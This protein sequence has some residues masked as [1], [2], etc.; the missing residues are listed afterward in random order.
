MHLKN[1]ILATTLLL[2]FKVDAQNIS[3]E[4]SIF[5]IQTGILGL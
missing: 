4:K 1:I 5:G 2:F 3:V